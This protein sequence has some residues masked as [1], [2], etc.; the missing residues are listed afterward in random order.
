M[1]QEYH[2]YPQH[3]AELSD[4]VDSENQN[5]VAILLADF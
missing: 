4:P 2:H 5:Y 1:H 3:H